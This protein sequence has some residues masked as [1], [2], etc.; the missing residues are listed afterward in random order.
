[1]LFPSGRN[2]ASRYRTSESPATLMIRPPL[3]AGKRK[4]L[5][6]RRKHHPASVRRNMHVGQVRQRL[7]HPVLAQ[8]VEIADQR[9]RNHSLVSG[10]QIQRPQVRAA[11]IHHA[12]I[13]DR[14]RFNIKNLLMALLLHPMPMLVHRVHIHHAIAV[15]QKIHPPTPNHRGHATCPQSPPSAAPPRPAHRTA[16]GSR[17]SR[18][19]S[20][21]CCWTA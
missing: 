8:L 5:A 1:M 14:R 19:C 3:F 10:L 2:R 13:P 7:S 16:T 21:W 17:L 6:P 20:V 9:N 15:R 4:H 11:R 18:P 12:P